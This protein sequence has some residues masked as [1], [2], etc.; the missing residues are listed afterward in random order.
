MPSS[1]LFPVKPFRFGVQLSTGTTGRE[2]AETARRME[3]LGYS[4]ATMPDHFGGQ[5][6][7]M[8]ALQAVLDA[9]TTL[10]A[11]ALVFDN[12]YKHPAILAKE[13]ATMDVLSDGRVEIGL[14]AGWMISDYEQL[15]IVYDRPGVRVDRF[16]EGLAVLRGAMAPGPFDF[17]G[18]HYTI[19]GYDGLPKPAQSPHPPILIGGGGK[20]VLTIAAREADIVGVNGTLDAGVIGP[21]AIATMTAEAVASKVAIVAEAAAAA[22]RLD[23]IEMNIRT[24]FVSVTDD[25]AGRIAAMAGMVGVAEEMIAA[26]PFALIGSTDEIVEDLVARRE[27]YGFSYVIVGAEDIEAFAPVVAEL[28]GT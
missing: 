5:L 11:G 8:P 17:D 12:D 13:L 20:R 19:T 10:R 1:S 9:T 18:E 25:R 2:W 21:E 14:G 3:A 7:P 22:G 16:A 27:R 28:A 23:H 6:A 24:F 15:G 4:V 26:S